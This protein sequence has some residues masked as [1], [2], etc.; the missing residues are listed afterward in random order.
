MKFRANI[1]LNPWL[2]F[3]VWLVLWAARLRLI[4][5]YYQRTFELGYYPPEADTIAIPIAGNGIMTIL[6]APV[7]AVVFWL[8]LRRSPVERRTWLA[9]NRKRWIISLAWTVVFVACALSVISGLA[10]DIRIRLPF[11]A[12][13]D[14][15]WLFLW[16]A[17][18]A[19]V[20]SRICDRD[21]QTPNKALQPT[22]TAPSVLTET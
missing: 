20:V 8:L 18:R 6:L 19:V 5:D 14:I 1:L 3:C 12:L 15:G 10:E 9:W 13:A 4:P 7:L 22:A 16:L 11:N 2:V 21:S 17:V